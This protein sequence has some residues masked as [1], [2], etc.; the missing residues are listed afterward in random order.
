[1]NRTI[2][3]NHFIATWRTATQ[4]FCGC[5]LHGIS[6]ES[7]GGWMGCWR[8]LLQPLCSPPMSYRILQSIK[9]SKD[10]SGECF[11]VRI[12]NSLDRLLTR[13]ESI[14]L[15]TTRRV[16]IISQTYACTRVRL[17]FINIRMLIDHV[18]NSGH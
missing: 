9:F 4:Y 18:E 17:P 7:L 5:N 12:E 1:M 13:E 2:R 8:T 16:V 6:R 10:L 14:L 11:A 15:A 3:E